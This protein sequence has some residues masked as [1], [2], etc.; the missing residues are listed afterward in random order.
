MVLAA[1]LTS[2]AIHI[3]KELAAAKAAEA[4]AEPDMRGPPEPEPFPSPI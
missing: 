2:A 1:P 4:V 3:S